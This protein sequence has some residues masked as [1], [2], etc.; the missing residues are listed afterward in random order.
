MPPRG[1][2]RYRNRAKKHCDANPGK[3][4]RKDVEERGKSKK[5]DEVGERLQLVRPSSG[6]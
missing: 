5:Q 3:K 1:E 6:G 2:K 4:K